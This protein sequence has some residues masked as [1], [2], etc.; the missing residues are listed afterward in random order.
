MRTQKLHGI[1]GEAPEKH[2]FSEFPQC[3]LHMITQTGPASTN[4]ILEVP[5]IRYFGQSAREN[6]IRPDGAQPPQLFTLLKLLRD[7]TLGA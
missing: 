1:D 4:Y 7:F 6:M 5:P 2:R 3:K